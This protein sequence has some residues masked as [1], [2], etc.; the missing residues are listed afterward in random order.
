M[1]LK[2]NQ[3]LLGTNQYAMQNNMVKENQTNEKSFMER[4]NKKQEQPEYKDVAPLSSIECGQNARGKDYKAE[5]FR[6]Q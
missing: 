5:Q 6:T 2:R 1:G 4:R 3:Q